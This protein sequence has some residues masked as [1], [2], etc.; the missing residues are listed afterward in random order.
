MPDALYQMC[1]E[2][3]G[4]VIV[5]RLESADTLWKQTVGLLGRKG[6]AADAGMWLEPC[7]GIHTFAMRFPL[8]VLFLDASYVL[9]R[10][11]A[12]V[13]P[14]R[15]CGPIWKARVVVELPAGTIAKQKIQIGARYRIIKRSAG[16]TGQ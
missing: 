3:T 15:I 4:R 6:L 5:A 16:E 2:K 9:L 11:V 13:A 14:W 8:D 1:E 12:R 10:A 7:N